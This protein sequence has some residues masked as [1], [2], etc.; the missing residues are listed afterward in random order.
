MG[1]GNFIVRDQGGIP[2]SW[3]KVENRVNVKKDMAFLTYPFS[4]CLRFQTDFTTIK[5][6][7]YFQLLRIFMVRLL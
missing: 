7:L 4:I 6:L 3:G 1:R 5:S 2:K